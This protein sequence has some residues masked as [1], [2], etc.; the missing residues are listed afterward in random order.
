[1][2]LVYWSFFYQHFL[3]GMFTPQSGAHASFPLWTASGLVMLSGN[4]PPATAGKKFDLDTA[5]VG[6]LFLHFYVN[7]A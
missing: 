2:T 6:F 1:M 5:S 3:Y 7:P 4:D